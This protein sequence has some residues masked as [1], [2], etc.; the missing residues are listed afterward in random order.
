MFTPFVTIGRKG[1]TVRRF[2][3]TVDF[4]YV[5]VNLKLLLVKNLN[6]GITKTVYSSWD[7]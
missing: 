2:I 5:S 7:G 1:G 6:G 4:V 3:L